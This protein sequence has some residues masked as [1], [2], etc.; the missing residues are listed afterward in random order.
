MDEWLASASAKLARSVGGDPSEYELDE[1]D[2]E[3][4][5]ELARIAAHESGN[6]TNAPLVCYLVGL[7]RGRQPG[8][9]LARLTEDVVAKQ[10][11]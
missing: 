5:L 2:V 4:L 11:R 10:P 3:V 7:A 9:G 1:R 8:K 6:R